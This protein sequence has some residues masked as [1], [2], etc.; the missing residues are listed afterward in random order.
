MCA[1]S[2]EKYLKAVLERCFAGDA[3]I[4]DLL[5]SHN[6]RILHDRI[7]TRFNLKVSSKD[8]KWLGDFYYDAGYPGDNFVLVSE[9]DAEECLRIVEVIE[10]NVRA[11]FSNG[12]S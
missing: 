5:H 6:L 12:E 1:Q 10:T 3:D 7:M 9:S 2:G 4:M 8:C 11:I